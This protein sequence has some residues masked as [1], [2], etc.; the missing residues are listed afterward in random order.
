M[1]AE[2]IARA[3]VS[4]IKVKS[5]KTLNLSLSPN[6]S[7]SQIRD[8]DTRTYAPDY[9]KT[10]LI[11]TPWLGVS[12]TRDNQM[13]RSAGAPVYRIN[14]STNLQDFGATVAQTAPYALTIRRNM[15]SETA[16]KIEIEVNY[17][18]P[19]TN[20]VT[21]VMQT[22]TVTKIDNA[23]RIITPMMTAPLGYFFNQDRTTLKAKCVLYRGAEEDNDKVRYA[24]SVL[25]NAGTYEAITASNAKGITGY[26]TSE[27]TIPSSAVV[28]IATYKCVITDIDPS[29]STYNKS[30]ESYI[31]V[32]DRTDPYELDM[33]SPQGWK[34]VDGTGTCEGWP[35]VYQGGKLLPD[36]QGSRWDY[37]WIAEDRN[38]EAIT[39]WGT[40]GKKRGRK[41]TMT[42]EETEQH[43]IEG[44]TCL[45]YSK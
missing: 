2:A 28:N 6:L 29:S 25:N 10:P 32:E 13:S 39:A 19:D 24:W 11:I 14:G 20:L 22:M 37:E 5:G 8:V 42:G 41:I 34:L 33:Y 36:P 43:R 30:V 40:Q 35:N 18:D 31:S 9:S 23:G 44:F 4:L 45:L 38:G 27:M 7:I 17:N 3:R 26:N 12:G 15:S 1:A 21:K 16:Y